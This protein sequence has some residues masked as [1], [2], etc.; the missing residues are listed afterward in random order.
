MWDEECDIYDA[1]DEHELETECIDDF[2]DVEL[3]SDIHEDAPE[4]LLDEDSLYDDED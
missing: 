1:L 3:D 2:A 4:E